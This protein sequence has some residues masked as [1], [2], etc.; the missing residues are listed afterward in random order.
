MMSK[1]LE[2]SE[3][4]TDRFWRKVNKKSDDEC[5]EWLACR[6]KDGYGRIGIKHKHYLAHRVSWF[7]HNGQIPEGLC[8]CHKCDN[9]GCV[10]PKH[11]FLGTA[12]ENNKDMKD[13]GRAKYC[14]GEKHINNKLT[15][16]QVIEIRKK[17]IPYKYS[18]HKLAKEYSVDQSVIYDIVTHRSWRHVPHILTGNTPA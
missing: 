16:K 14:E 12:A 7:V 11:L 6:D 17:Y 5:W 8:A 13:K 2:L 9:P 10:N 1:I 18:T 3:K 4:D 15:K